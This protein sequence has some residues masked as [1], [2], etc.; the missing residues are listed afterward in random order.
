MMKVTSKL[1]FG[2]DTGRSTHQRP[3]PSVCGLPGSQLPL[4]T[5][6]HTSGSSAPLNWSCTT[7]VSRPKPGAID[8]G[9][10]GCVG[11][12]PDP[13]PDPLPLPVPVPEPPVPEPVPPGMPPEPEVG[14]GRRV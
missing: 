11:F 10:G 1:V 8:G 6:R 14:F 4:P 9:G 5:T 7:I 3:A 2:C 13:E 12:G